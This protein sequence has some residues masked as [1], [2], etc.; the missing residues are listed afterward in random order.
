MSIYC[1]DSVISKLRTRIVFQNN[2]ERLMG[3]F[4]F[5]DNDGNFLQY[6]KLTG[7]PQKDIKQDV[8]DTCDYLQGNIDIPIFSQRFVNLMTPILKNEVYFY[9]IDIYNNNTHTT[10]YLTKILKYMDF[11]DYEK[12]AH[13]INKDRENGI[14]FSSPIVVK[15][16]LTPFLIARDIKEPFRWFIS[17]EFKQYAKKNRLKIKFTN[18]DINNFTNK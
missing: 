3:Y 16:N 6:M 15:T 11:I 4:I 2:N 18:T 5:N 1:I 13:A 7:I 8:L 12:T 17:D 10:F 9:P 14:F